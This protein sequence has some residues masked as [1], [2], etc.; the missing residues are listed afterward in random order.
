MSIVNNLSL[1][2]NRQI[3]INFDGGDL[4]SDAGL[5]LIKEFVSKLGID[6][7]LGKA[8]KT[9]DPAL[10][11]YHTDQKNLLQ[12]IYM[13]I[14]GY[15]EDDASDKLTNDPSS[16]RQEA[17]ED[18]LHKYA[19]IF[20]AQIGNLNEVIY[21]YKVEGE[22][23]ILSV[24]SSEASEF[25]GEDIKTVG[26][27][28]FLL[29]ELVKKTELSNVVIGG[30]AVDSNAQVDFSNSGQ[31]EKVLG[32]TV[33]NYAEDDICEVYLS[34]EA[35]K[36]SAHQSMSRADGASLL[37][38]ENVDFQLIPED[39]A[40]EIKD[41]SKATIKLSVKDPKGNSHKVQG[42]VYVDLFWGSKYKLNLSG[43]TDNGYFLGH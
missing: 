3:K 11:R 9:N 7:L 20:L 16:D 2:S 25:A 22:T 29:E 15:F 31:T 43:D 8:F 42:E 41:G 4:S 33:V 19:Y 34:V 14:A 13:I 10:F 27:D 35:G 6:K 39:F 24:T 36:T 1:E 38:G 17:F 26:T 30:A 32:F 21:E 37:S 5:L 28:I 40:K 18:R 23:R 12:M